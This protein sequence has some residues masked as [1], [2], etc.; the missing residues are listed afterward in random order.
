MENDI[1]EYDGECDNKEIL[2]V[3]DFYESLTTQK[4]KLLKQLNSQSNFSNNHEIDGLKNEN[5]IKFNKIKLLLYQKL[6]NI[7][8]SILGSNLKKEFKN[9]WEKLKFTKIKILGYKID[10]ENK[11]ILALIVLILPSSNSLN[12]MKNV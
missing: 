5:K 1:L 8:F 9:F 3:D 10:S 6:L 2:I 11:V 12:F 7:F 4:T